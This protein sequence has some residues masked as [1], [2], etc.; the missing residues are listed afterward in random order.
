MSTWT[1]IVQGAYTMGSK[2]RWW[3]WYLPLAVVAAL[4]QTLAVP[5]SW[6]VLAPVVIFGVLLFDGHAR[7]QRDEVRRRTSGV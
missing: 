1:R 5:W 7:W 2:P 3:L 4:V 6:I